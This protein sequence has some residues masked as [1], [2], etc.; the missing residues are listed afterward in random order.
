MKAADGR[1]TGMAKTFIGSTE[2][3]RHLLF[4]PQQFNTHCMAWRWNAYLSDAKLRAANVR[5]EALKIIARKRAMDEV[6][7]VQLAAE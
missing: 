5:E 1:G 3:V 4:G 2:E 7:L 6:D